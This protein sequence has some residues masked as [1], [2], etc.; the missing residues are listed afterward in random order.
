MIQ[1][2]VCR[3]YY[4]I[5]FKRHS[6][7]ALG[8]FLALSFL[9]SL[10]SARTMPRYGAVKK[11]SK[12]TLRSPFPCGVEVR[13]N[14]AYGPGCS[15]A[16]KRTTTS[17]TNDYYALDMIRI[18]PGNGFD[19]SVVASAAGIVRYAGWAKGGWSPYGKIVY[20]EHAI[21]G[22]EDISYQ[23]LYGHLNS[24]N[25]QEGQVVKDGETIGTLGGSSKGS[26]NKLGHHLHFAVYQNAKRKPLGGGTAVVPEPMGKYED[27][28]DRMEF[29]SCGDPDKDFVATLFEQQP[30]A[31]GG[32][33]IDEEPVK[34][35]P[36]K[37]QPH[38][39]LNDLAFRR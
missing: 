16:H 25:V 35:A 2:K 33:T 1:R 28:H 12:F 30:L 15:P 11:H 13:V 31:R 3:E 20:I 39:A 29:V 8:C 5:V 4:M 37:P 23:T 21:S 32:L 38:R 24:V 26:L 6:Y 18:E 17:I 19:K 22:R 34:K 14:C 27:F 9:V 7:V 36:E 10:G